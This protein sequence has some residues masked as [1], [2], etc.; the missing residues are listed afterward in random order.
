MQLV[1][2]VDA[3]VVEWFRDAGHRRPLHARPTGS[4]SWSPSSPTRGRSSP[5]SS[6]TCPTAPASSS[7]SGS[8]A[9][10]LVGCQA[11]ASWFIAL[12]RREDDPRALR[13]R[14]AVAGGGADPARA[15]LRAALLLHDLR[16]RRDA[17]GRAPRPRVAG[18]RAAQ[19]RLAGRLRHAA[20]R[21][22][23]S[24]GDGGG[25]LPA[26]RQ[27]GDGLGGAAGLRRARFRG[28]L[29]DLALLLLVPLPFF[30]LVAW[31]LPAASWRRFA[32]FARRAPP[33]PRRC[34]P[35]CTG[36]PSAPSSP[37]AARPRPQP[38]ERRLRR[39]CCPTRSSS[40]RRASARRSWSSALLA[41]SARPLGTIVRVATA[42]PALALTFDDGPD[43]DETPRVLD[44]LA[45]HGA[46]ATFFMVGKRAVAPPRAGRARRR[47]RPCDRQPLLGPHLVPPP[48][49]RRPPRA[50]AAHGR[51]SRRRTRRRSSA[52]PSASRTCL[53]SSTR[54]APGYQV[55]GWDVVPED[56][57]DDPAA[58]LVARTLRRL[59]RGSI[60]ALPR[61]PLPHRGR[62]LSRPHADA[63]GARGP[64][65]APRA[66]ASLRHRPRAARARPASLLAPLPPAAGGLPP[67][68]GLS[69]PRPQGDSTRT[70]QRPLALLTV[71]ASTTR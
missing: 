23:G 24:G 51:R 55:V 8:S 2:N 15:R 66:D 30:A 44:L 21:P 58:L 70:V 22:L 53:R 26:A 13:A 50:A 47:R 38:H 60:V 32:R 36:A 34:S 54:T 39:R 27:P 31:L 71:V 63:R 57:R 11:V 43:P 4:S 68:P 69:A 40:R 48:R 65:R 49:R 29:G 14:P 67:P 16:R 12:Q 37:A 42:E 5:R 7:S 61:Q 3:F 41:A 46:R 18:D 25:E 56:W 33:S 28:L 1:T 64:A 20:H 52:R 10:Q 62:A 59:R 9:I 19:P 6:S 35:P 45:A 17:Q